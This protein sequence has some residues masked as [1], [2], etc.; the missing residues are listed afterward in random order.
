MKRS[1]AAPLRLSIEI[2]ASPARAPLARPPVAAAASFGFRPKHGTRSCGL[3]PAV[4]A[5][6]MAA[7]AII[8]V[9]E[10]HGCVP[11]RSGRSR[12]PCRRSPA[13][14]PGHQGGHRPCAMAVPPICR[15]L[16]RAFGAAASTARRIAA[17]SSLR[18]LSSVTTNRS[19]WRRRG[20]RPS[21]GACR[22]RGRR[23]HR[24]P[25]TKAR[26]CRVRP[27]R[28]KGGC[29]GRRA[30]GRSRHRR[31]PPAG[32]SP[33]GSSRPGTPRNPARAGDGGLSGIDRRSRA[34]VRGR[35]ARSVPPESRRPAAGRRARGLA[36]DQQSR[37][38][39]GRSPVRC[40]PTAA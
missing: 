23:R 19:A 12:G 28:R 32:V 1:P 8:A 21:A 6:A 18:G 14:S 35:P 31:R 38:A 30:C 9:V 39:L 24:R 3:S 11:Q 29:P 13:V 2:A 40:W 25:R 4:S 27:Q 37:S 33:T 34:P 17:G 7:R 22:G 20:H 26:L 10:G 5:A 15:F 16:S 36:E